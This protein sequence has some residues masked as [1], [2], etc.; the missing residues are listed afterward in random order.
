MNRYDYSEYRLREAIKTSTSYSEVLRKLEIPVKGN[1]TETLKRYIKKFDINTQHFT[2]HKITNDAAYIPAKEY[3]GTDKR[4]SAC[5]LLHKLYKE[6]FKERKCEI[7]G[8]DNWQ[9]KEITLQLHH[10]DGN[11]NNNLLSNL[12]VLCP[13]CHSQTDNYC[14]NANEKP[15]YYCK[16]CGRTLRTNSKSGL[17]LYCSAKKNRRANRPDKETLLKE[18]KELGYSGTGRKYGVSDNA[19]RKW[20]KYYK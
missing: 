3:L 8:I 7:C 4:I 10:I 6:G 9:G 16:E 5:K 18:I 13:N 11:H 20:V 17:C 2:G 15:I 19:I 14:G 1:N 12:Q